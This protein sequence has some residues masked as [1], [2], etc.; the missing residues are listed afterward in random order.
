MSIEKRGKVKAKYITV[1]GGGSRSDAI[2]QI[3][4]DL[5]NLPVMKSETYENSSLGCAMAQYIAD[6]TY[7]NAEE[8]R[9][10]MVRYTKSFTPNQKIAAEYKYLF[11][12][13]YLEMYPAL[14]NI[15]KRLTDLKNEK[16][17]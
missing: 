16:N 13:A 5:F 2:C 7:K 10:H 12:K 4:S 9:N 15:Y 14:K 6:G 1:A 17:K 11:E 3:T 8:A